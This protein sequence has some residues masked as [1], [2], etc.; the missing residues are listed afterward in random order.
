MTGIAQSK[1]TNGKGV[2]LELSTFGLEVQVLT[3]WP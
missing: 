3:M 1:K 2:G